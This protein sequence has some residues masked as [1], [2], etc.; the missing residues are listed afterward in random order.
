MLLQGRGVRGEVSK[1][2]CRRRGVKGEVSRAR[3]SGARCQYGSVELRATIGTERGLWTN[4]LLKRL[5]GIKF[6][7]IG[8]SKIGLST[9]DLRKNGFASLPRDRKSLLGVSF[10]C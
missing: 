4:L 10:Y 8:Y 9:S 5:D 1:A 7:L 2:R 6:P 3:V